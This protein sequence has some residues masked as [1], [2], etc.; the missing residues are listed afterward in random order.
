MSA[1]NSLQNNSLYKFSV[2]ILDKHDGLFVEEKPVKLAPKVLQ[3]LIFFVENQGRVITKDE[4]FEKLWADT[5]VE[6]NALSFNISQLR[7]TLAKYDHQ[8][9]FIET[10]PKRGFRFNAD[11]IE[12]SREN[13]EQEIV[14]EKHQI[15]E[16]IVEETSDELSAKRLSSSKPKRYLPFVAAFVLLI[17]GGIAFQYRQ[18]NEKMRSIDS[19]RTTKLTSWKSVG[20]N[21]E[22]KYSISNSGNLFAYSSIKKDNEEIFI[23]QISGG[24]D[25]QVTKSQWNNFSPIWSP[26]DKQIAFA[27]VRENQVGIYVCPSLGGNPVLLEVIGDERFYLIKWS[28]DG[29]KIFY[30]HSGNIFAI[31]IET[32]E[33]A[34]VTNFPATKEV[35][36]FSFSKDE[37]YIAYCDTKD[38]QLDI[39]A[40]QLPAGTPFQV[41]D[42]KNLE[43]DLVWHPDKKRIFYGVTRN[44]H[45]QINVGFINKEQPLQVTRS[46]DEHKLLD[47]STDGLKVFFISWEDKSDIWN[48]DI[49]SRSDTKVA[50]EDDSEFWADA[51][52]DGNL[53]SY[54]KNSLPN[55]ISKI[56]KSSIVIK[57]MNE[58]AI[59]AEVKGFNQKW[60]PDNKRLAFLR[61]EFDN[62]RYNIWVFDIISGE[63][64]QITTNGVGFSGLSLMPYNRSQ[65]KYFHWSAES[66]QLVYGDSKLQNILQTSTDSNETKNLTNND[67]PKLT[68]YS[69]IW[70]KDNKKI[71]FV[72]MLKPQN[73][74]E[75]MIWSVWLSENGETKKVFSTDESLRLLGWA[76]SNE[77]V[78]CLSSEDI[79]KSAPIDAKLL[80]ISVAGNSKV[81]NS[82]KQISAFSSVLSPDGKNIAFTKR[83]EDKDD[84]YIA[85]TNSNL[86]N[87]ITENNDSETLFGSL[88]WSS[89]GKSIFFDKQEKINIISV[90]DNLE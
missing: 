18:E 8:T 60:L 47:I 20:S 89:D 5:F 64:K 4:L 6:D 71:A 19:L 67:N 43:N 29:A 41:T 75:K 34:Q 23:K 68:F 10:I 62:K 40:M 80:R 51:S 69:P 70:S 83:V 33:I 66:N 17:L 56:G 48:V 16:I 88:T 76:D 13:I 26:E 65:T 90:I 38:D 2:F 77:E 46:D 31:N 63:E 52:S 44:G 9:V 15:Q 73:T 1:P 59:E 12:I 37:T 22:T 7:K 72:S 84:I 42:D 82:F 24:E 57:G 21:D 58:N 79:M 28:N 25:I 78:I 3:T 27:S 53:L 74:T 55:A 87:K 35:R 45:N 50:K 36:H 85:S 81:I 32:K 49:A 14:Y 11:I 86:I 30:E 61:W 39:W 54:Q